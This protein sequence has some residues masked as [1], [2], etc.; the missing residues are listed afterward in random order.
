MNTIIQSNGDILTGK[1]WRKQH[2]H[3]HRLPFYTNIPSMDEMAGPLQTA[4]SGRATYFLL[5]FAQ[6]L[7][8]VH[9]FSYTEAV[10]NL[11]RDAEQILSPDRTSV[12]AKNAS[13]IWAFMS[14]F[15]M[16]DRFAGALGVAEVHRGMS[17]PK[18]SMSRDD[19]GGALKVCIS[20]FI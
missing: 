5:R 14:K 1:A 2:P 16:L 11:V 15:V 19:F 18:E 10:E 12:S 13:R 7:D 3:F 20:F 8:D 6:G 17:L 9:P 4:L